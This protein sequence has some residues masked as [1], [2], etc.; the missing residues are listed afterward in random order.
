M[1][2]AIV[3]SGVAGLAAAWLLAPQA[4]VTL[5]EKEPR[6]GGHCLTIEVDDPKGRLAVDMG[7]VVFNERNYPHLTRFFETLGVATQPSDM[8]FSVSLGGGAHEWSGD[9]LN[10]LFGQ[11]RS[12]GNP[13][14]W[15]M[16][17]DIVRFNRDARRFLRAGSDRTLSLKQFLDCYGYGRG[18]RER[19][20]LPMASAIWSTPTIRML[21]APAHGILGFFENHGLLN[22]TGRPL[23]RTVTGGSHHYVA[24]VLEQPGLRTRLGC[25]VRAIQRTTEGVRILE[26]A[27]GEAHY[28]QVILATHPDQSL[29]LLMD[30][31]PE[32]RRLLGALAYEPNRALLHTDALL[33]PKT[34]RLW[35][36]WNYLG[37]EP[38]APETKLSVTY[39]MNRLQKLDAEANYFVSLNPPVEP[40]PE[41]VL[42]ETRFEHPIVSRAASLAQQELDR[43]Q[44]KQG[45]W[46]AGAWT[47]HGFHEDGFVSALRVV[48]GLGY[49]LPWPLDLEARPT[50]R[51]SALEP[52]TVAVKDG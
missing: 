26:A 52:L 6:P 43:I 11:R 12:L 34:R 31:H 47:G 42:Y 14:H 49:N 5:Y 24:K 3:G 48:Q 23:W 35:S 40:R 30:A 28:D 38:S 44:G 4:D 9:N 2:I 46:F 27:G 22:L 21:E 17:V 7:F 16:L 36:S 18:L 39:W 51:P 50:Q 15:R 29:A 20:L 13:S 25:P 10:K 41:H 1:R 32:E 19:Y 45:L 33:M 37:R 8:S